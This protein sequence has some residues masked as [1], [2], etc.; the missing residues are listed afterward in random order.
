[1]SKENKYI[2]KYYTPLDKALK[3]IDIVDEMYDLNSYDY[4]LEPSA[5]SG[6][7]S[8][9]LPKKTIAID[10]IPEHSSIKKCDFFDFQFPKGKGIVIGNPPYGRR[11]DLAKKFFNRCGRYVDVIA[12]VLPKSMSRLSMHSNIDTRFHLKYEENIDY[13]E[14][15]DGKKYF[16]RSVFQIWEKDDFNLREKYRPEKSHEDFNIHHFNTW[17]DEDKREEI[18]NKCSVGLGCAS[19]KIGPARHKWFV[20]GSN[21]FIEP[22]KDHVEEIFLEHMSFKHLANLSSCSPSIAKPDIIEEYKKQKKQWEK[23]SHGK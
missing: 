10:L 18:L 9:N 6:S 5:G 13:F 19:L 11:A 21:W 16:R 2:D 23:I 3:Y 12:F 20:K 14:Y 7:F 4:I 17:T 15:P 1:M 8:L 22:L